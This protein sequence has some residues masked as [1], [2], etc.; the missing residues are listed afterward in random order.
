M[1]FQLGADCLPDS[2]AVHVRGL[3]FCRGGGGG[4]RELRIL[5]NAPLPP[6]LNANIAT[7]S[8]IKKATSTASPPCR[9]LKRMPSC[10]KERA[11][12]RVAEPELTL[13]KS[14]GRQAEHV[15]CQ[16]PPYTMRHSYHGTPKERDHI[17]GNCLCSRVPR[18]RAAFVRTSQS[19]V[20][21][22][23][24]VLRSLRTLLLRL[25]DTMS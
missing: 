12:D 25:C 9:V 15:P 2:A 11:T 24:H 4:A 16:K 14:E 10:E 7:S 17:L 8:G 18:P 23:R 5:E 3:F 13:E 22:F 20:R 21:V 19:A 6:P 1:T